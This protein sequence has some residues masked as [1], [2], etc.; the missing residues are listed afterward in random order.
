MVSLDKAAQQIGRFA[1][2][3]RA[4]YPCVQTS[5][6]GSVEAK[7]LEDRT[8]VP[9]QVEEIAAEEVMLAL[10]DGRMTMRHLETRIACRIRAV[11]AELQA[12][13]APPLAPAP[14]SHLETMVRKLDSEYLRRLRG[15]STAICADAATFH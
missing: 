12:A 2:S 8:V 13:G 7:V 6:D 1:S 3:P 5:Q 4:S 15:G 9:Q 10:L 14:R 11:N